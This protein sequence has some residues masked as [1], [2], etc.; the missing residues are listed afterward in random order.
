[1]KILGVVENMSGLLCPHC[2]ENV[3]LFGSG[4]GV[5][6]AA[7]MGVPILG[8]IP[9]DPDMVDSGDRGDLKG[10]IE[11]PDLKINDAYNRILEGII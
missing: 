10:L 2:G 8:Q 5:K 3:P 1:M 9:I 6:M 11:R 4:G 7:D